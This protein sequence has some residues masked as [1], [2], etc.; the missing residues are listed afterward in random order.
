MP[1]EV[2]RQLE[3]NIFSSAFPGLFGGCCGTRQ[4]TQRLMT[5]RKSSIENL[6]EFANVDTVDSLDE[7]R[8]AVSSPKRG[9]LHILNVHAELVDG[10]DSHQLV[11]RQCRAPLAEDRSVYMAFDTRYCSERCRAVAIRSSR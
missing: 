3:R 10:D 2:M 6:M 1:A 11:C 9:D 8:S 5:P 4:P 7:A